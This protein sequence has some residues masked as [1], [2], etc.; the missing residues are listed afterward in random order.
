[1]KRII[2]GRAGGPYSP[3]VVANGLCFVAGQ[4]G[5]T[6]EGKLAEG[7]EG[8]VRQA[9]DNLSDVLG[10]AGLAM[11]DV[12]RTTVYLDNMDDFGAM[13]A[14][15]ATYFPSDPPART[16][17]EVARLP[18]NALVEVDAIAIAG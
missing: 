7:L 5:V 9:L 15:Y 2:E 13:N 1:M 12:V 14:V 11:T 10:R 6:A 8:Q 17:I 16:T 4:V 18:V 3:A